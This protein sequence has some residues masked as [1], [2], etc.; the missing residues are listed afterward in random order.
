MS[1]EKK[2]KPEHNTTYDLRKHAEEALRML[3]EEQ[4]K[5]ASEDTLNVSHLT[6]STTHDLGDAARRAQQLHQQLSGDGGAVQDNTVFGLD[7]VLELHVLETTQPIVLEITKEM[8]IGRSDGSDDFD[9]GVDMSP[10][11]AYRLGLSRRHALLRRN[12]TTLEILDYGSRNGT[13]VNGIKLEPETAQILKNGDEVRL[14]NLS[15]Q[16]KF[17]A[18]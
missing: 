11:G 8:V 4:E 1:D 6:G 10:F 13:S 16:I 5:T 18:K 17:R 14:G 3:K 7:M 9:D 12:G 2:N 15:L